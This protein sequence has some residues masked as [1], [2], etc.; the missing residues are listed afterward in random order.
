MAD[1]LED[2]YLGQVSAAAKN[3]IEQ[4]VDQCVL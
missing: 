3:R 2:S 1:K 4:C